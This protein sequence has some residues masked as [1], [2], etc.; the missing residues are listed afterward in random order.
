M[1]FTPSEIKHL[2]AG[3]DAS[4]S[5]SD[6]QYL[7]D[8]YQALKKKQQEKSEEIRRLKHREHDL[9]Y[10][11]T[12]TLFHGSVFVTSPL[13]DTI[14]YEHHYDGALMDLSSPL[15]SD[16]LVM[17]IPAD[18]HKRTSLEV[19]LVEAVREEMAQRKL[20]EDKGMASTKVYKEAVYHRLAK[21]TWKVASIERAVHCGE[22]N[23]D[24]RTE[25]ETGFPK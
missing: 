17:T 18:R 11:Q 16:C 8:K 22:D 2:L 23:V 7:I 9:R 21:Q 10:R 24:D 4:D 25:S 14:Q 15:M 5:R 12:P 3:K 1:N 6:K 13:P 20:L 19:G